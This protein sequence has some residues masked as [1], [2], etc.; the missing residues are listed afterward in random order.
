MRVA[1]IY[2]PKSPAPPEAAPF[3]LERLRGWCDKH[4]PSFSALEFFMGGGGLGIL[5]IDNSA[6]LHRMIAENPFTPYSDVEI[7]PVLDPGTALD[8]MGEVMAAAAAS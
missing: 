1:V 7:R 2:R 6:E 4:A 3:M 5:D 8:T